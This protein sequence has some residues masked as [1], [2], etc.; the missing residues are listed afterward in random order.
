MISRTRR[1]W[2]TWHGFERFVLFIA[3]VLL[4]A[5]TAAGFW[6]REDWRIELFANFKMQYYLAALIICA[7]AAWRRYHVLLVLN[8][9][10]FLWNGYY[11]FNFNPQRFQTE[12]RV[13]RAVSIN[14]Y[15][16]NAQISRTERWIREQEP[17]FV[18]LIEITDEW[19]PTLDG[20][21]DI[22]PYQRTQLWGDRYGTTVLSKYPPTDSRQKHGFAGIGSLPYKVSTPDGPLMLLLVH[23][24][25]PINE[26]S[27]NYRDDALKAIA[28]F[29]S[30]SAIEA[31]VLVMGDFNTTPWSVFYDDFVLQSRLDPVV[32]SVFPRRTWP[33]QN[34]ILWIPI[35]HFF[36]SD[37]LKPVDQYIGPDLGSDHY[38]IGLDFFFDD[39]RNR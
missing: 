9:L 33:T 11:I 34:P 1:K 29:S 19:R 7:I 35:D 12:G 17:D 39:E 10:V 36:L 18:A 14:V 27:W 8:L 20:L 3:W 5:M 16:Q 37:Q 32:T 23:A 26:R 21:K 6:G 25:S 15:T 28:R 2:L 38:P 22:L 30:E 13:Y 4:V 24:L 31:P